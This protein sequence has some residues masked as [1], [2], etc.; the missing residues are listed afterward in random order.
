MKY[1]KFFF[2]KKK[3]AKILVRNSMKYN[4]FLRYAC[5]QDRTHY[6]VLVTWSVHGH[7][8]PHNDQIDL[9]AVN[10]PRVLKT[11]N[12]VKSISYDETEGTV[13]GN[14]KIELTGWLSCVTTQ[15][16]SGNV[17]R[18]SSR[19]N[20]M[21]LCLKRNIFCTCIFSQPPYSI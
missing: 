15:V 16:A 11:D 10:V 19:I 13:H 3:K 12:L 5:V 18:G 20:A 8:F 6:T 17:T 7:A 14:F 9:C 1:S 2:F 4:A 21:D